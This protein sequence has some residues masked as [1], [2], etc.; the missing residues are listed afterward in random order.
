MGRWEG[1]CE[2]VEG[3]CEGWVKWEACL[4]VCL[5]IAPILT[6][7]WPSPLPAASHLDGSHSVI[8][9]ISSLHNK[10]HIHTQWLILHT[11]ICTVA[12]EILGSDG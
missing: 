8:N 2:G 10:L 6:L 9:N 11:S 3:G 5:R 12:R 1:A 4:S 7:V